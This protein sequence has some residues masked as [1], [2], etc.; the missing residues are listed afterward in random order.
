MA[1]RLKGGASGVPPG[2]SARAP[3]YGTPF[4]V[5]DA[6]CNWSCQPQTRGLSD[7]ATRCAATA[8]LLVSAGK[9]ASACALPDAGPGPVAVSRSVV[10]GLIDGSSEPDARRVD[11]VSVPNRA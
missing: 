3:A 11:C 6:G 7:R 4:S 10:P 9:S 5:S 1:R 2:A 8:G